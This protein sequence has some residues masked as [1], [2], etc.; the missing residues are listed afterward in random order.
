[1]NKLIL[2]ESFVLNVKLKEEYKGIDKRL[3]IKLSV[4]TTIFRH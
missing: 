4:V 3:V 1:M 2:A